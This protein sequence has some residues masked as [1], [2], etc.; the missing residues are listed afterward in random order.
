MK[1][2]HTAS[3]V[4]GRREIVTSVVVAAAAV[5]WAAVRRGCSTS[6]CSRSTAAG[7]SV[8]PLSQIGVLI[9][10]CCLHYPLL[11]LP[12]LICLSENGFCL[13]SAAKISECSNPSDWIWEVLFKGEFHR[14]LK[15]SHLLYPELTLP[16]DITSSLKNF[17]AGEQQP[18]PFLEMVSSI[19][20]CLLNNL[21]LLELP[22][23]PDCFFIVSLGSD[24]ELSV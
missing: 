14:C 21:L 24:Y 19:P 11:L 20:C 4:W 2:R 6:L 9:R 22:F 15:T 23:L 1:I 12:A 3:T 10:C 13:F 16:D 7:G 17:A 18:I 8:L 5:M